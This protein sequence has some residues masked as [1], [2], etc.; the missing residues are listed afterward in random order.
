MIPKRIVGR[1]QYKVFSIKLYSGSQKWKIDAITYDL[2]HDDVMGKDNVM[3]EYEKKF[4]ALGNK[5]NKLTAVYH[6]NL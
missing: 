1:R 2:H 6:R 5:I 3:T 4:S